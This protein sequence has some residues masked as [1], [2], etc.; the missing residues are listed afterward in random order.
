MKNKSICAM[1]MQICFIVIMTMLTLAPASADVLLSDYFRN[2]AE[3]ESV[4]GAYNSEWSLGAKMQLVRLM[5]EHE[6]IASDGEEARHLLDNS[7]PE[8]EQDT[9]ASK[10]IESYYKDSLAMDTYNVMMTEL[11]QMTEWSYEAKALYSSLLVA[12]GNQKESWD[13][14]LLPDQ[15]DVS[16]EEAKEAA[17]NILYEKFGISRDAL[18]AASIDASFYEKGTERKRGDAEPVWLLLFSNPDQGVGSYCV[19]LSRRGEPLMYRAPGTQP[20][21]VN[22]SSLAGARPA[23]P[24]SHD[25]G[26]EQVIRYA[27]EVMCEVSDYSTQEIEAM[28]AEAS[29][30]Y[31]ERFCNGWEPVWLIDLYDDDALVCKA[32]YGY[33]GSYMDITTADMEFTNCIR[34]GLFIEEALGVNFMSLGFYE[35][36]LTE[37]AEFSSTWNA[38]IDAYAAEHPYYINQGERFYA[39]TRYTYGLPG[40]GDIPQEDATALAQ[41]KVVALGADAQTVNRRRIEYYFDITEPESPKWKLLLFA[42]DNINPRETKYDDTALAVY[43]VVINART[44]EILEAFEITPEM[45]LLNYRL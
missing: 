30:L 11:G 32:L 2:Y 36:T 31:H 43:R 27:K 14:F 41:Q 25:A 33:D 44:A 19:E 10:I 15:A 26:A 12:Y 39:A 38:V 21:Y 5:L 23:K 35:M 17:I 7:L 34:P 24:S 13:L 22:Q 28:R 20:Y 9:L 16:F 1:A 4:Y 8:N 40:E 3:L 45:N 6:L 42:V 37:R 18:L 29:F